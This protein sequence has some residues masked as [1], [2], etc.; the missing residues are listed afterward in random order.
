MLIFN[1]LTLSKYQVSEKGL[2]LKDLIQR[3]NEPALL[4]VMTSIVVLSII[5]N[6]LMLTMPVYMLQVYDRVLT[7]RNIFTLMMLSVIA[8]FLIGFAVYLDHVRARIAVRLANLFDEHFSRPVFVAQFAHKAQSASDKTLSPIQHL[9]LLHAFLT[10]GL[11]TLLDIPWSPVFILGLMLLHPLLGIAALIAALMLLALSALVSKFSA[12]SFTQSNIAANE[13]D[14]FLDTVVRQRD[15]V[16]AL[17]I[18]SALRHRWYSKRSTGLSGRTLDGDL[19]SAIGSAG[20]FI[21]QAAQMSMLGLGAYLAINDVITAGVIVAGSIVCGR[22]LMP[23]NRAVPTI[24]Q[25]RRSLKSFHFLRSLV[26]EAGETRGRQS[27]RFKPDAGLEVERIT[28]HYPGKEE[29]AIRNLSFIL[30]GHQAIGI[31]GPSGSGKSTL[32]RV[33]VGAL[34]PSSGSVKLDGFNITASAA[35]RL[36]GLI[37]YVAQHE[38]LFDATIRENIARFRDDPI[39]LVDDALNLVNLYETVRLLPQGANTNLAEA[40]HHLTKYQLRLIELARCVYGAP[41][42]IV[43][44]KPEAGLDQQGIEALAGVIRWVRASGCHLVMISDRPSLISS[45]DQALIMWNGSMEGI[46]SPE[47]ILPVL[48]N[49]RRA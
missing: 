17:G 3:H 12:R 25:A 45:L 4:R 32:A 13:S 41:A 35:E 39:E 42:L 30:K 48:T 18:R 26:R 40:R 37:G 38:S 22:A 20:K 21:R 11:N 28:A 46:A 15:M 14:K 43:L 44:D 27:L 24:I 47:R 31:V 16:L 6:L 1:Q 23:L 29:P 33:L 10:D 36:E 9:I 49:S 8:I 5:V 7:S 2:L 34:P 19:E